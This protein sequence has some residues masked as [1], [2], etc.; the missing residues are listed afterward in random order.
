[1]KTEIGSSNLC[2]FDLEKSSRRERD[3][4]RKN[5]K[6]LIV[7]RKMKF[8]QNQMVQRICKAGGQVRPPESGRSPGEGNG[9]P[10]QYSSQGNPMDPG[11]WWAVV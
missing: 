11:A 6:E 2:I 5:S 3:R 8:S 7:V 1:M 10:F 4:N 9:S